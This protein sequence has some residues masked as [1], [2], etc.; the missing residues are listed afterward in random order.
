[1][2]VLA[3][4]VD[5]LLVEGKAGGIS[6]AKELRNRYGRS[7]YAVQICTVKSDK[8]AS[9]G[10]TAD[11]GPTIVYAPVRDWS[12][13]LIAQASVFPKGKHEPTTMSPWQKNDEEA[14]AEENEGVTH[15]PRPRRSLYP[16]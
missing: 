3:L 1:M 5:K 7:P 13:L 9:A 16:V 6:A 15:R 10:C 2:I 14:V 8:A 4:R 11:P 12:D